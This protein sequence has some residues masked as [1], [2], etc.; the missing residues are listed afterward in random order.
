MFFSPRD[1][2]STEKAEINNKF[3]EILNEAIF[4]VTRALWMCSTTGRRAA[5]AINILVECKKIGRRIYTLQISFCVLHD[6]LKTWG[7]KFSSPKTTRE[8]NSLLTCF[9]RGQIR[10]FTIH[11]MN[12]F[13]TTVF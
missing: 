5:H 13:S 10:S 1:P 11:S 9:K 8:F 3:N 6:F 7:W 4:I 12:F 2:L